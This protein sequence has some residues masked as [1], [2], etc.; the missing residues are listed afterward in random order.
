MGLFLTLNHFSLRRLNRF[1]RFFFNI[2]SFFVAVIEVF[3]QTLEVYYYHSI[4]FHCSDRSNSTDFW[5]LFLT[6]ILKIFLHP[7]YRS[8]SLQRVIPGVDEKCHK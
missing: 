4:I 5:G 7:H 6:I 8:E 1:R 2:Q 3:E